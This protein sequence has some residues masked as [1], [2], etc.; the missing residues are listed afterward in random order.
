MRETKVGR[1]G[2]GSGS[3]PVRVL[4]SFCPVQV[5][6]SALRGS[7]LKGGPRG[8]NPTCLH[9]G[10]GPSGGRVEVLFVSTPGLKDG[11]RGP[12][13]LC[14]HSP[15][16]VSIREAGGWAVW[17]RVDV[18][19]LTPSSELGSGRTP[20]RS[21]PEYPTPTPLVPR[22]TLGPQSSPVLSHR[23]YA[24]STPV[25]DSGPVLSPDRGRDTLQEDVGSLEG[26]EDLTGCDSPRTRPRQPG[27]LGSWLRQGPRHPE[28]RRGS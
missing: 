28:T 27:E 6:A 17:G 21:L 16:P 14:L 15:L 20:S 7:G 23:P 5:S 12:T 8:P 24:S 10:S 19:P 1:F 13:P 3:V 4:F 22:P 2:G 9:P 11:P 26:V 18:L 25:L